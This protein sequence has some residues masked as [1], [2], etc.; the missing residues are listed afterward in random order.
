MHDTKMILYSMIA[1]ALSVIIFLFYD[2]K[3]SIYTYS[4]SIRLGQFIGII[5]IGFAISISSVVFQSITNNKILTPSILGFDSLYLMVQ[6]IVIYLFSNT[7]PDFWSVNEFFI[8]TVILMIGFSFILYRILFKSSVKNIYFILLAGVVCGTVFRSI[9]SFINRLIET[10]RFQLFQLKAYANFDLIQSNLLYTSIVLIL[11][12]GYIVYKKLPE[13]DVY[14]IGS[15]NAKMLG[16]DIDRLQ[17]ISLCMISVMVS[18]S[19]VLVGPITFLGLIV[20]NIAYTLLSGYQL[21]NIITVST[22]FSWIILMIGLVLT[23]RVITFDVNLTMLINAFGGMY[24]IY[25][26][27]WGSSYDKTK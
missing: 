6:S 10:D 3:E 13:L 20:S 23:T 21:K 26:L 9:S 19:T 24:F 5:I 18:I 14:L 11:V 22:L 1:F 8:Y 15:D 27:V 4:L 2:L 16:I 7:K 25:L 12:C 17:I